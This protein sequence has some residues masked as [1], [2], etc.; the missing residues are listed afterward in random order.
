MVLFSVSM[1]VSITSFY[2]PSVSDGRN[3]QIGGVPRGPDE[4]TGGI[5]QRWEAAERSQCLGCRVGPQ[6]VVGWHNRYSSRIWITGNYIKNQRWSTCYLAWISRLR[7]PNDFGFGDVCHFLA[8][9][10]PCCLCRFH[11]EPMVDP[12]LGG[13]SHLVITKPSL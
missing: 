2:H 12:I 9:H 5:A 1:L 13:L 8:W 7:C 3:R 11:V 6:R 10:V 4:T